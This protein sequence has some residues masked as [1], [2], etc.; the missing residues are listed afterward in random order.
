M[1]SNTSD[2]TCHIRLISINQN[3]DF[4]DS[5]SPTWNKVSNLEIVIPTNHSSRLPPW[6]RSVIAIRHVGIKLE[7]WPQVQITS[8]SAMF[9]CYSF[10]AMKTSY[11]LLSQLIYILMVCSSITNVI[12]HI[13][14]G[15][16]EH[17]FHSVI[18]YTASL[19]HYG[20]VWKWK[21]TECRENDDKLL[22]LG[23]FPLNFQ[24][25]PHDIKCYKNL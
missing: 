8:N 15:G 25:N 11:L 22:D 23:C 1:T 20:C 4:Y 21:A 5:N 18:N 3:L 6:D 13:L 17:V 16:L 7:Q 19:P 12:I 9:H 10:N 2:H 14:V 24:S